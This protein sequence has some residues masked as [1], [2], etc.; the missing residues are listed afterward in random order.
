M[1]AFSRKQ[2]MQREVLDLNLV[3]TN[4]TEMLGPLLGE[5]IV[6]R[7]NLARDPLTVLADATM[8]EQIVVN[9]AVN[10][11]DAMP[12]GG[13][14]MVSTREV[15][16]TEADVRAKAE[17]RAGK[18]ARLS[19]ADTGC[20]MD[21]AV[22]DHLFEPFFT[23]KE[24]GKGVGLGLATVYG[25]VKQHQG[26]I[27]VESQPGQGACF[28]ITLPFTEKPAEE[29]AQNAPPSKGE[30]GKETILV[31]EDEEALR[32]LVREVLESHGYQ[33]LEAGN[34]VEALRVWEA[35]GRK[36]NLLL[37]DIVMP[38]G[39]SGR[40]LAEKLLEADPRL[41]VIL[42]SGYSQDMIERDRELDGKIKFFSKPYH[43]AQLAQAVR[44]S[45]DAGKNGGGAKE[46]VTQG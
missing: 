38:E 4:A 16:L 18:F 43:P 32:E 33:V 42:T 22:V 2:V 27:E 29:P 39:M 46:A 19:V 7:L 17:R 3:A 8:I 36:V 6:V 26:W 23:T 15:K 5:S 41:P 12:K 25:T 45:L 21:A 44:E 40:D 13:E 30:V 10:A 31:V 11:R 24:V 20:G 28:H 34:G 35:Q 1:L 9:L 14:L 37:S